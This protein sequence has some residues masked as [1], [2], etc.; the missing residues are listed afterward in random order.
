MYTFRECLEMGGR[1]IKTAPLLVKFISHRIKMV[2]SMTLERMN[3]LA[4]ERTNERMKLA[5]RTVF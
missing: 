4:N 3:E 1:H 2:K 5:F